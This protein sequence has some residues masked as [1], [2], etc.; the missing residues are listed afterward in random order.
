VLSAHLEYDLATV[1][2]AFEVAL[3]CPRLCQ[4]KT[5]IDNHLKIFFDPAKP[6]GV[7]PAQYIDVSR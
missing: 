4:G 5:P 7:G 3:R 2:A 6:V 1:V